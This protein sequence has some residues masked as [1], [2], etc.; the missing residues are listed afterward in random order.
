LSG[1]Y[2]RPESV[3]VLICT[4]AGDVLVMERTRPHGFWQSVTG[5]LRWGES[6][7]AAALREVAEETGLVAGS[8]LRD[9]RCGERFPIVPPW[10]AS[11]A[12]SAHVNREHW[13]VL[14]LNG[15]RSIRLNSREHRQSRWLPAAQAAQRVTSW[16]NSKLIRHW[17]SGLLDKF[18]NTQPVHKRHRQGSRSTD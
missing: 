12:P 11:Y 7:R 16:T 18:G 2:K 15:R 3:L 9:L 13:F 8:A 1:L 14:E 10:R 5:S 6:A 17:A 4:S